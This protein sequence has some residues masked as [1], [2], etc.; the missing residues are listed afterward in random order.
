MKKIVLTALLAFTPLLFTTAQNKSVDRVDTPPA[1]L[2]YKSKNLSDALYWHQDPATGKWRKRAN[3]SLPRL[4]DGV[5]VPN[6]KH[7]FIGDYQ[8]HRYLFVDYYKYQ[9]KYPTLE[10]NWL[11]YQTLLQAELT[12]TH[13]TQLK[14]I[15]VGDTVL[16]ETH[17]YNDMFKGHKEYSFPFLL[18]LTETLRATRENL[19]DSYLQ[20]Y[21]ETY[22]ERKY[23]REYPLIRVIQLTR[24]VDSKGN[25]LIRF[26]IYP[27]TMIDILRDKSQLSFDNYYFETPYH[28]YKNLFEPDKKVQYK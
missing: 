26:N 1:T 21:G 20:S 22:G 12:E 3:T 19:H 11:A 13:Y 14:D 17:S 7:L 5:K 28:K 18:E 24:V 16:I 23:E 4:G 6:F 8:G 27:D 2:S 15:Q 25:D 10:Q 9:W